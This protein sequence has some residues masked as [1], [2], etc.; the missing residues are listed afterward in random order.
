MR[1]HPGPR[2]P[3]SRGERPMD[4][5]KPGCRSEQIRPAHLPGRAGVIAQTIVAAK[6]SQPGRPLCLLVRRR[7][8][9]RDHM[10]VVRR[11]SS[12][13]AG[14]DGSQPTADAAPFP[15]VGGTSSI[16]GAAAAL[17]QEAAPLVHGRSSRKGGDAVAGWALDDCDRKTA[18]A[19]ARGVAEHPLAASQPLDSKGCDRKRTHRPQEKGSV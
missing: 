18:P 4:C 1:S 13:I 10:R 7:D 17:G 8:S 9:R 15:C 16:S 2:A 19:T 6:A 3:A 5:A 11:T 14:T 12:V